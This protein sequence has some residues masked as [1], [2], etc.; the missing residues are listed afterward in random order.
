MK[1][2]FSFKYFKFLFFFL[3]LLFYDCTDK[4]GIIK[5]KTPYLKREIEL[6]LVDEIFIHKGYVYSID[7]TGNLIVSGGID[8]LVYVWDIER[9]KIIKRLSFNY[10][11][12]WGIP[13][14]LSEDGDY[15]IAGAFEEL[16]LFSVK[17]DFRELRRV[18]A[19]ERG[20]QSLMFSPDLTFVVSAGVDGKI[21][22]WKFPELSLIKEVKEHQKEVWNISISK[23][24]KYLL[25][26]GEDGILNLFSFPQMNL[27]KKIKL[28]VPVEYVFFSE[29]E[30]YF[31][32]A[33]ADG[34]VRIWKISNCEEYR[35][36]RYHLGSALVGRFLTGSVVATG[37]KDECLYIFDFESGEILKKFSFNSSVFSIYFSNKNKWLFVGLENGKILIYN[38]SEIFSKI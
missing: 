20:I 28:G 13:V 1:Q 10:K 26:G 19:N 24:G 18:R 14:D 38:Y 37:G 32:S 33:D 31:L 22:L 7:N 16:V 21:K 6:K 12:K 27:I 5:A 17:D 36:F 34:V 2:Q 35:V 15:L 23:S 11:G 30:K 9:K 25:S 8:N 29:D 3:L 4:Q